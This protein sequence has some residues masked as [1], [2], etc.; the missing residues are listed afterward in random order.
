MLRKDFKWSWLKTIKYTILASKALSIWLKSGL[1]MHFFLYSNCSLVS[2]KSLFYQYKRR[3]FY[4]VV[5]KLVKWMHKKVWMKKPTY[6][7][8]QQR[9]VSSTG[10]FCFLLSFNCRCLVCFGLKKYTL[11]SGINVAPWINVA[12]GKFGKKNKHSPIY[13]LYLYYLNRLY[14]VRN[15]AVAPGK[16]SKN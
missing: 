12:P 8:C 1:S 5:G 14:G 10:N 6:L 7:G 15:K 9:F 16:K 13:T 11:E 4:L 2:R 3:S